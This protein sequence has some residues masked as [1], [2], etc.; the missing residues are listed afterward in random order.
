[1]TPPT[2]QV[3]ALRTPTEFTLA[4]IWRDLLVRELS[5]LLCCL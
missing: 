1:M 4:A 3:E 2:P 5:L